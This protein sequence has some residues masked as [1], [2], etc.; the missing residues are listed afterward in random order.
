MCHPK[1]TSLKHRWLTLIALFA[2]LNI[3]LFAQSDL[4]VL[5]QDSTTAEPLFGATAIIAGTTIGGVADVQGRIT[6]T[7]VPDGS[8]VLMVRELGH[9]E[10][11]IRF[12]SPYT[13]MMTVKLALAVTELHEAVIAVT[14]T[15]SRIE[16]AP[17]KIEVLGAE[18]LEE[19]G[20]LKPG[21]I[22]SLIGDI[23]SVQIQQTSAVSGAGMVRMQGLDGRYTLLLRDGMP[24]YGG[25]SGGFD[26]MRIPPLDLQRVELL[27]GPSSTFNGAGAIAGAINFVSK[28][29]TDSLHALFMAN[30]SSLSE[31]NL[32]AFVSGPAGPIGFTL[33]GATNTQEARD[34]NG[35]EYSDVPRQ[36]S[37]LL[38]PQVFA[39]PWGKARLRAGLLVQHDT[40]VGGDM[41][42]LD[43]PDDTTRFFL[44]TRG[45]R[46]GGDVQLDQPLGK[47]ERIVAKGT[48]S[49]YV[50]NDDD[51]F[52]AQK[53]EQDNGYGEVYWTRA[54]ERRTLVIGA[55]AL[56]SSLRGTRIARQRLNTAG[57]FGQLALHRM[58][59]PEID[60][61]LRVD[62][63]EGQEPQVL[64]SIGAYHVLG[65]GFSLRGNFGTGYQLPD[66]S[67]SY[68][69]V[70]TDVIASA[71]ADGVK[72][73]RSYGGTLEWTWRRVID[74]HT[75]V[76]FD[77]TFF[78]TYISE[79]LSVITAN[80]SELMLANSAGHTFTR[81][82]DNYLR[83]THAPWELYLGYTY[84]LPTF[85]A[86]GLTT[87][88]LY[89][90]RH[91]A[92]GTLA[93]ELGE[94][95]RAGIESAWNGAQIRAN[96]GH[97]REQVFVAAMVGCTYGQWTVVLN[98]ENVSDTRQTRWEPVVSG[99]PSRPVF[100]PLWAPIDGRVINLSIMRRL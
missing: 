76:F 57:L 78:G 51:N 99:S 1:G 27:K 45:Q 84:T 62:A 97:T 13:G 6:I 81:G 20:S 41:N 21:N 70:Y 77:Q 71:T 53:R 89:T 50:Q 85:S 7:N 63:P 56:T 69:V 66:R 3:T 54:Q 55:S 26:L 37:Y 49:R 65:K 40:R 59:W 95:W 25:L 16:D 91:R 72:P 94:H 35:D 87:D 100:A 47:G 92:A 39:R 10:R 75:A 15:N 43:Q 38:H 86:N 90:P 68:S 24:A 46:L 52:S 28:E 19:E 58:R 67:R 23:S 4:Q 74:E 11:R 82:V 36:Q 83:I 31:T 30:R 79:P 61:G 22:A 5:V 60:I 8:H 12:T 64:P 33:F 93:R 14:R 73:E 48:W 34:V 32:N 2:M 17:Q 80:D 96:G 44:R 9:A 18:D 88:L 42:A 29:P 98:G